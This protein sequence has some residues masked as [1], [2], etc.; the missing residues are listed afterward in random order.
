M[1]ETALDRVPALTDTLMLALW[2]SL[3]LL[4]QDVCRIKFCWV[5]QVQACF[6][7]LNC[8]QAQGKVQKKKIYFTILNLS[9]FA[10]AAAFFFFHLSVWS[11]CMSPPPPPP[12]YMSIICSYYDVWAVSFP[13]SS[14]FQLRS[15]TVLSLEKSPE[16]N[17]AYF[18]FLHRVCSEVPLTQTCMNLFSLRCT[19]KMCATIW[20]A[21]ARV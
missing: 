20:C 19:H 12:L 7:D 16:G 6:C 10:W 14:F 17:I 15:P 1:L 8:F 3:M 18:V 4:K 21:V 5:L 13:F 2:S 11:F 9:F